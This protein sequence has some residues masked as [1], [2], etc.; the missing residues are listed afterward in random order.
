MR[1]V[2]AIGPIVRLQ[3]RVQV[4]DDPGSPFN[5]FEFDLDRFSKE[6][7][8]LRSATCAALVSFSVCGC[9]FRLSPSFSVSGFVAL[10]PTVIIYIYGGRP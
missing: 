5:I 4:Q 1:N 7:S 6:V 8:V 3:E 10:S 9:L 2:S